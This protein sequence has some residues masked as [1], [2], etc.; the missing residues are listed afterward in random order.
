MKLENLERLLDFRSN[1]SID[2]HFQ[3]CVCVCGG[4]GGGVS[5]DL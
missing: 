1:W 5:G 3:V 2:T 4:G